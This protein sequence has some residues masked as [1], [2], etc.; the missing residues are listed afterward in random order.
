RVPCVAPTT[1][2][3]GDVAPYTYRKAFRPR[4]DA[5]RN[6]GVPPPPSDVVYRQGGKAARRSPPRGGVA[7]DRGKDRRQ[8]APAV[9]RQCA[10]PAARFVPASRRAAA[11][12]ASRL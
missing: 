11:P 10:G 2:A 3:P 6:S 5:R 8:F 1:Y 7:R 9:S 12:P 4:P